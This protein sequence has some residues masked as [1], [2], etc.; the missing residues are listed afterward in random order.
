MTM[1]N[2]RKHKNK[3][4]SHSYCARQKNCFCTSA[5]FLSYAILCNVPSEIKIDNPL[6]CVEMSIRRITCICVCLSLPTIVPSGCIYIHPVVC[7]SDTPEKCE[8]EIQ[9]LQT[10]TDALR[11]P[12]YMLT[13]SIN[14]IL[15]PNLIH[16]FRSVLRYVNPFVVVKTCIQTYAWACHMCM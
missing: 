12:Q 6:S 16:P 10:Q 15:W 13:K 1:Y 2:I 8:C 7:S 4:A 5:A 9:I 11:H 14:S 3:F